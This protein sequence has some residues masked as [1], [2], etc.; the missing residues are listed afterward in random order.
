MNQENIHNRPRVKRQSAKNN[1][2]LKAPVY[3][4]L[5]E[6]ITDKP[7]NLLAK[8]VGAA[9]LV[10]VAILAGIVGLDSYGN[11]PPKY[12][13]KK[14][15][16][17]VEPADTVWN[18]AETVKGIDKVDITQVVDYIEADPANAATF[19]DKRLDPGE[20]LVIP[21]SVER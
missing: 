14:I 8:R 4:Q 18:A 12:S 13:D 21:K 2:D 20:T 6:R 16:F 11:R 19:K 15:E 17:K 5:P 7:N 10:T 3:R 9:A 1:I